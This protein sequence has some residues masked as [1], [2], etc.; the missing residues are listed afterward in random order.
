MGRS[1]KSKPQP[2]V[3]NGRQMAL[4]L[5]VSDEELLGEMMGTL[6]LNGCLADRIAPTACRVVFPRAWNP[7]E[8]ELEVG[9][10]VRAWQV[11]HPGVTAVLSS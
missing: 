9:F 6:A 5:E 1:G 11:H 4:K 2:V 3:D 8:A 10:F 7:R